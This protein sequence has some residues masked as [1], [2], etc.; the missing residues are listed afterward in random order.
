M[1]PVEGGVKG[2]QRHAPQTL[3]VVDPVPADV[4]MFQF[5]APERG[6]R[7]KTAVVERQILQIHPFQKIDVLQGDSGE[8][9]IGQRKR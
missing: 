3:Q 6:Q 2:L 8:D 4:Q 1:N 5:H 9:Q 7:C